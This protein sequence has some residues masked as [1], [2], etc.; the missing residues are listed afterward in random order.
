MISRV[1][2]INKKAKQTLLKIEFYRKTEQH[3]PSCFLTTVLN[4]HIVPIFAL[5]SYTLYKP[6]SFE[7][8]TSSPCLLNS[9]DFLDNEISHFGSC[10]QP[11]F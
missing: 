8:C 5:T 10:L 11:I 2:Y 1:Q 6:H 9:R 3:F 7:Q 4:P